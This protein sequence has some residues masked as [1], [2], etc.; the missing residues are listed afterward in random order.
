[1][2][3]VG[4]LHTLH[5]ASIPIPI[6][7]YHANRAL[8]NSFLGAIRTKTTLPAS[9]REL[10]ICRVATLNS[11]WYE[12][13]SHKPILQS[14]DVLSAEVIEYV[15][16]RARDDKS[17]PPQGLL[18][19]KHAAVLE[20]TEAMTVGVVVPEKVFERLKSLFE[21]RHV[22]ELTATVAA[23]N[24]VSRFLVALDVGEMA[25]KYGVDMS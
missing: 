12:W 1:M 19:E 6:L 11:A 17:P 18:D 5:R 14:T 24:C 10:A 3:E 20:Y 2:L 9:V 15:K 4:K 25:E 21:E 22:V 13:D 8:R 23:Y 7:I 16:T